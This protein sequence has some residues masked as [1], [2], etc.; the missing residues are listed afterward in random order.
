MTYGYTVAD[1]AASDIFYEAVDFVKSALHF[2]PSD[3]P[4]TDVDG[5]IR[6]RF[7]RGTDEII[8]ESDVQVDYVGIRSNVSLPI[9]CLHKWTTE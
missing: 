7:K 6:Q 4:L 1:A 2:V 9:K 5:S 8:V 3:E